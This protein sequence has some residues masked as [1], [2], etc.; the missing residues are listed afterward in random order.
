MSRATNIIECLSANN[1]SQ[2]RTAAV[3]TKH[4]ADTNLGVFSP[5]DERLALMTHSIHGL[6]VNISTY[7]VPTRKWVLM[8][9]RSG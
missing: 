9:L 8:V 1:V 5:N 3:E 6:V 4:V 7:M 2:D